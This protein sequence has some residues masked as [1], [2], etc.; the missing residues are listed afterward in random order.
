MSEPDRRFSIGRVTRFYVPLLLQAFSQSVSYPLVG[1]IVTHGV[2]GVSALNGFAQG[3]GVMFMIGLLGGGLITTGMVHVRDWGTYRAFRRLNTWMMI[4]LLALQALPTIQPLG[5]IVFEDVLSLPPDLA[6]IARRTLLGGLAMNGLFF[7]RN[8]PL[9]ILFNNLESGKANNATLVRIVATVGMS[10]AFPKLGWVGP[11][12]GLV[13]MTI[14]VG[15]ECALTWWRAR[16]YVRE[17]RTVG[18]PLP[19]HSQFNDVHASKRRRILVANQFRFMLPLSF[20]SFVL[21]I[22]PLAIAAFVGRAAVDPQVMLAIHYVTIGVANPVA[23]AALRLQAVSIAFPPTNPSDRRTLWYAMAAGGILGLALLVFSIPAIADAYFG[24]YQN[25]LPEHLALARQAIACYC[26]WVVLQAVRARV[27]GLAA[28]YKRPRTVMAGQI[29]Y[30]VSLV[31]AMQV[32]LS[33]AVTGWKMA[34][35]GI[36]IATCCTLLVVYTAL[37]RSPTTAKESTPS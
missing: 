27:E 20:G 12:W 26:V 4:A 17:L 10:I 23:F 16:P 5:R 1:G 21:A 13:A 7:L 15:I 14:G 11:E 8:I 28:I 37:M 22:S 33:L 35:A 2:L 25:V 24:E 30:L 3:L 34:V 18:K 9:V 19:W 31:I 36:Y 6:E 29:A 32:M